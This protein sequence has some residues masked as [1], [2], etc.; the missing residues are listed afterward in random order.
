MLEW[1]QDHQAILWTLS[2]ASLVTFFASLILVPVL[3]VRIPPDYFTHRVRP[4]SRW[5]DQ[6]PLIRLTLR[7]GKNV[8]GGL[9]VLAGIAMLVLPGQGLLTMLIGFLMLDGPGK[10]R[11]EKWLIAR[12]FVRRPINWLRARAG[13]APLE[14]E[15]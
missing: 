2:A 1:M 4:R 3:V 8:L 7:V 6:H 12:P 11:F 15:R 13:H 5:A 14:V 10:Y 9:F